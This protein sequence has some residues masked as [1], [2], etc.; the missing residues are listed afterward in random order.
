M[1]RLLLLLA[2]LWALFAPDGASDGRRGNELYRQGRFQEAAAAYQAGLQALPDDAP[3]TLRTGLW[4]N[5]GLARYQQ[6]DYAGAQDAFEQARAA[7][8]SDAAYAR[9]SYNAGNTAAAQGNAEDALTF[10]RETLLADPSHEDARFN[11]EFVQRRMN[12]QPPP[13][14]NAP[15]PPDDIQPSDYAK[16]LKQQAETLVQQSEYA[17]AAQIMTEG[18][19]RDS[20]VAAYRDFITRVH[21]VAHIDEPRAPDP[22]QRGNA[23][24]SQ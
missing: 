3:A 10:F 17:R 21:E 7:A 5:L 14:D 11:Y 13:P 20:T 9:A 18:L 19:Q 1:L 22:N 23:L 15:S 12:Q 6:Q 4:N 8:P 2:A 16:R 24:R